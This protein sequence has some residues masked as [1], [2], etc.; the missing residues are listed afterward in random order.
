MT[1]KKTKQQK[2]TPSLEAYMGGHIGELIFHAAN[3]YS[4][5]AAIREFLQ[6]SID[7]GANNV[8]IV[9]RN[10]KKS[11]GKWVR[12]Y[13][14]G[15]GASKEEMI[16]KLGMIAQ[17]NKSEGKIG[18]LGIGLMS[19]IAIGDDQIIVTKA[20][21]EDVFTRF[22]WNKQEI[23]EQAKN[24]PYHIDEVQ[25][26]PLSDNFSRKRLKKNKIK[27]RT[28]VEVRNIDGRLLNSLMDVE[29]LAEDIRN[30]FN[31]HL[32]R[33][34]VCVYVSSSKNPIE[35]YEI[36]RKEFSGR[37]QPTMAIHTK[38]GDVH[39]RM[40]THI[41]KVSNPRIL[42][43]YGGGTAAAFMNLSGM[44]DAQAEFF[45]LFSGHFEGTISVDFCNINARRND[46]EANDERSEFFLAILEYI[47]DYADPF[48]ADIK[49][50]K[51]LDTYERLARDVLK[52][53]EAVLKKDFPDFPKEFQGL[54]SKGHKDASSKRKSDVSAKLRSHSS[55]GKSSPSTSTDSERKKDQKERKGMRHHSVLGSGS[56]RRE[57]K[58]QSGMSILLRDPIATDEEGQFWRSK[59]NDAG[60][61]II[62]IS[63]DDWVA[64]TDKGKSETKT[65]LTM[66][67]MKELAILYM[68][69][70]GNQRQTFNELFEEYYIGFAK[71]LVV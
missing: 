31:E 13:D 34:R 51:K 69:Q 41:R 58:G 71:V 44:Y 9:I 5:R 18:Q 60:Y 67:I 49:D 8:F 55:S 36:K 17:S 38:Y 20:K 19:G 68:P 37:K 30:A 45:S 2:S 24:V 42:V 3:N 27:L 43:Q 57:I 70:K 62:N 6:N 47:E 12:V 29:R 26:I 52:D 22:S 64:V 21:G 56:K 46:F 25:E 32:L 4:G 66:L 28:M 15:C 7:A 65:Y 16:A 61:I 11:N 63:H 53:F 14:D 54:V 23:R 59:M 33:V 50:D 35:F 40:H 10:S 48:L 1:D 39:F